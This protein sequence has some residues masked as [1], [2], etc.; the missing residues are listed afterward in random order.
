[1]RDNLLPNPNLSYRQRFSTYLNSWFS[2]SCDSKSTGPFLNNTRIAGLALFSLAAV[3][4]GVTSISVVGDTFLDKASVLKSLANYLLIPAGTFIYSFI[5]SLDR[6]SEAAQPFKRGALPTFLLSSGSMMLTTGLSI[7]LWGITTSFL[8]SNKFAAAFIFVGPIFAGMTG[9]LFTRLQSVS[10]LEISNQALSFFRVF[11]NLFPN[12][13]DSRFNDS[14]TV[15]TLSMVG[16]TVILFGIRPDDRL[17]LGLTA[18]L[19]LIAK[20]LA[21]AFTLYQ[22]DRQEI[23]YPRTPS[24]TERSINGTRIDREESL[25]LRGSG[26]SQSSFTTFTSIPSGGASNVYSSLSSN[27]YSS[28]VGSEKFS[29]Q[30]KRDEKEEK[31]KKR[32][33]HQI[34]PTKS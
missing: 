6:F 8:K 13:N 23:E 10:R 9:L 14:R 18:A 4:T 25:Y 5:L 16:I 24:H 2:P 33:D 22:S 30:Q 32:G 12:I 11:D 34:T 27:V 26:S 7:D 21:E 1:M 15:V 28:L 17:L 3:S 29:K 19:F 31:E 20:P